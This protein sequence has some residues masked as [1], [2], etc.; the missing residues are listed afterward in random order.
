LKE[1]TIAFD[2]L[3]RNN[4][5]DYVLP[6]VPEGYEVKGLAYPGREQNFDCNSQVPKG[7]HNERTV[8]YVFGRYPKWECPKKQYPLTD[9]IICHGDV[10]NASRGYVHMNRHLQGFGSYGDILIRDRKMYVAPTP[11]ALTDGTIGNRTLI[12]PAGMVVSDERLAEVGRLEREEVP[13]LLSEYTFNL[14][15]NILEGRLQ[16]NPTKGKKHQFVAYRAA[17]AGGQPVKIRQARIGEV[18]DSDEDV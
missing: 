4:Y 14:N 17:S 1:N 10:L 15:S 7:F 8:F 3:G 12:V 13:Q 5:P 6:S 16:E 11:F 18:A 9:L 2:L